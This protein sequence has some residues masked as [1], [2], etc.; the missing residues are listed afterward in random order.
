MNR[1]I[2]IGNGFDLA[3]N[4][5]TSYK[6]FINDF[7]EGL[8]DR[9][10][11][12]KSTTYYQDDFLEINSFPNDVLNAI[13]EASYAKIFT[14][15]QEINETKEFDSVSHIRFYVKNKFLRY[16]S[17]NLADASWVDIENEYHKHLCSLFKED[18]QDR[19]NPYMYNGVNE[20]H[21]NFEAIRDLLEEYLTKTIKESKI[22]PIKDIHEIFELPFTP[23]DFSLKGREALAN[24]ICDNLI[25]QKKFN[26][27][28]IMIDE[29]FDALLYDAA[30]RILKD[31]VTPTIERL[32]VLL[33]IKNKLYNYHKRHNLDDYLHPTSTCVVNF[34]YTQLEKMYPTFYRDING[35]KLH[36]AEEAIHIHGEL[37]NLGNPIIF[38][39]G[40]EIGED[41]KAI[42]NLNDNR[43]LENIKSIKYLETTNYNRLLSFIESGEYQIFVLGHSCGNSDRTLLNTLFEHEN[44]VSIKHYYYQENET[45]DHFS[46]TIRNI[47]RNFNDKRAMRE[48]VVN[49]EYTAPLVPYVEKTSEKEAEKQLT[50]TSLR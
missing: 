17:E 45:K 8:K 27:D 41:Y 15:L 33:E 44:C 35:G 9:V 39:Y 2:L 38:G 42:E 49:K 10:K 47:S 23:I 37:N 7:W 29:S 25:F 43:Y 26:K 34:N 30:F 28:Q 11:A 6:G 50:T 46:D 4:I 12:T 13:G 21:K 14:K 19:K 32:K 22:E 48:K 5:D 36:E 16:I 18:K 3:H 40:D 31:N 20:L 1:I 24:K